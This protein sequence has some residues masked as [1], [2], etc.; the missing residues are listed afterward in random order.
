MAAIGTNGRKQ[1]F[2]IALILKFYGLSRDG[3]RI[4]S[5]FGWSVSLTMYDN[6]TRVY[7]ERAALSTR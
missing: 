6:Y 5:E 2:F 1:I 3:I 4:L 7:V